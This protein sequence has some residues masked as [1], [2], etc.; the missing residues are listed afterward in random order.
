MLPN[1]C[2]KVRV[3]LVDDHILPVYSCVVNH[4]RLLPQDEWKLVEKTLIDIHSI[5]ILKY[6]DWGFV[7]HHDTV[8]GAKLG[9]DLHDDAKAYLDQIVEDLQEETSGESKN[10]CASP[11]FD[12]TPPKSTSNTSTKSLASLEGEMKKMSI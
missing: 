2:A 5:K 12:S 7:K 10:G 9:S 4:P 11:T 1:L 3:Q 6:H 8:V